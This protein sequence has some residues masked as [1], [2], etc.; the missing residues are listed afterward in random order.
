VAARRRY[1][2]RVSYNALESCDGTALAACL[3]DDVDLLIISQHPTDDD[4][5][6]LVTAVQAH[7][8][9]G[10]P[11]LYMHYDGGL[12]P[13]GEALIPMLGAR[14]VADNYWRKQSISGLD[15]TQGYGEVPHN[16][17]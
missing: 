6:G 15:G 8:S 7:I 5:S 17:A 9:A 11:V 13:I 4:I 1:G 16:R 12:Y 14:Y 10:R 3:S 2:E